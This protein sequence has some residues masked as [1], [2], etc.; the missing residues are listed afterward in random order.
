MARIRSIK[1]EFWA[2]EKLAPLDA[3]TRLVFLGLISMADDTGRLV[4]NLKQID[5]MIFP[6][7]DET[8]REALATLSRIG[9]IIRG[10][11]ANGQPV[12]QVAN[13]QRHQRV[14]HPNLLAA[15]PEIITP[16]EDTEIPEALANDSRGIPEVLASRSTI[17]DQRSTTNDQRSDSS[18]P[19]KAAASEPVLVF[20]CVGKGPKK[21]SVTPEK[22][23]EW[24]AAF[25]AVDVMAEL[26]HAK[27]WIEANPAKRKTHTGMPSFA[28]RWLG[29]VQNNGGNAS[30]PGASSPGSTKSPAHRARVD[31]EYGAQLAAIEAN[32]K[33]GE[34]PYAKHLEL[35]GDDHEDVFGLRRGLPNDQPAKL[36]ALPNV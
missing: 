4:D 28:V 6:C 17:Y 9:R 5:A 22:L 30:R 8:S 31:E 14:D 33:P 10:K 27:A 2:D 34:Q 25:P 18:E 21:Y 15:L 29:K 12:V 19:P 24:V 36:H 26:R 11:T 3:L 13:W 1:P 16:H 23:S 32:A 7:T 35:V 20:P